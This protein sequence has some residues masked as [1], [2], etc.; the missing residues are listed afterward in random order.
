MKHL[1]ILGLAFLLAT[2]S[3]QASSEKFEEPDY[4]SCEEVFTY[5]VNNLKEL[6]S[7]NH[8]LS[9]AKMPEGYFLAI[10]NYEN[11]RV[12]SYDYVPI[13]KLDG[14]EYVRPVLT[15]IE[16]KTATKRDVENHLSNVW[17]RR[18]TYDFQLYMGY[19]DESSD[20][21]EALEG[22][23]GLTLTHYEMLARAYSNLGTRYIH[24][25]VAGLMPEFA[26]EFKLSNHEKISQDRLDKSYEYFTK[27]IEYWEK[28]EKQ[29][30]N[31][32]PHIIKNLQ[33]KIANE[34]MHYWLQYITVQEPKLAKK[35]LDRVQYSQGDLEVAKRTLD[36]CTEN[37]FLLTNGDNDSF[38]FWFLQEKQGYRKDVVIMNT[39]LMQTDWYLSTCKAR[40][41]YKTSLTSKDYKNFEGLVVVPYSEGEIIIRSILQDSIP[42]LNGSIPKEGYIIVPREL[43]MNIG[44]ESI[45]VDL[46][47]YV[48]MWHL[49][50]FDIM[51]N[52][53]ERTFNTMWPGL[54]WKQLGIKEYAKSK[55]TVSEISF[56]KL[57]GQSTNEN[58]VIFLENHLKRM[59]LSKINESILTRF[60]A[61]MIF[62]GIS[63]LGISGS[64]EYET[65]AE[66]LINGV[67]IDDIVNL[68]DRPYQIRSYFSMCEDIN[69]DKAD[70]LLKRYRPIAL[71]IIHSLNDD[72]SN[73]LE[74]QAEISVIFQLYTGT[75]LYKLYEPYNVD[76]LRIDRR[77]ITQLQM[78]LKTIQ[79]NVSEDNMMKTE[80][81]VTRNLERVNMVLN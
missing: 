17:N 81:E 72:G 37:S 78:K 47:S 26:R 9:I 10:A 8:S 15:G 4:P 54:S 61:G 60:E 41:N 34:K 14:S 28:I 57:D 25:R 63:E 68:V 5:L 29:D 11:R 3:V 53:P 58:T 27:S 62:G 80:K 50:L 1:F 66:Q 48:S 13:W 2:C 32:L 19:P 67:D 12:E 79:S 38:P 55:S 18:S 40:H 31:Y 64:D 7:S 30:P 6:P 33:L 49:A 75:S 36:N 69:S 56:D 24:P 65:I 23:E 45:N 59:D 70:E 76:R 73:L 77:L 20:M 35:M 21:I 51:M 74:K 52:N 46:R 16:T 71:N 42:K 39:S 22:K 44:A 43:K